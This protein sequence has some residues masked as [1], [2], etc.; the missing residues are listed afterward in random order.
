[1]FFAWI[2]YSVGSGLSAVEKFLKFFLTL[3]KINAILLLAFKQA[4]FT[5]VTTDGNVL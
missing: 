2:F 4:V 3:S 5:T 1:M